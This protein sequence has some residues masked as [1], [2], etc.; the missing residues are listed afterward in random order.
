[1]NTGKLQNELNNL[2]ENVIGVFR[3]N[4]LGV[5][6]LVITK[7]KDTIDSIYISSMGSISSTHGMPLHYGKYVEFPNGKNLNEMLNEPIEWREFMKD[8]FNV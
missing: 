3:H 7:D 5:F 6:E 1:M 8:N 2:K 4:N